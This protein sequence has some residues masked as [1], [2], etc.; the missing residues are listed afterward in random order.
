ML[1][2]NLQYHLNENPRIFKP[3]FTLKGVIG[4]K[5]IFFLLLISIC[6]NSSSSAVVIDSSYLDLYSVEA[7]DVQKWEQILKGI[8]E[9]HGVNIDYE[10]LTVKDI[11]QVFELRAH[12]E[13][14]EN[15]TEES[16]DRLHNNINFWVDKIGL[17]E[18][19]E[20]IK[21]T[22]QSQLRMFSI[23]IEKLE[24]Y[25]NFLESV[26]LVDA[27]LSSKRSLWS[28]MMRL[29]QVEVLV[30]AKNKS[31]QASQWL[32]WSQLFSQMN[33]E[34]SEVQRVFPISHFEEPRNSDFFQS[35][36]LNLAPEMLS[37]LRQYQEVVSKDF[38]LEVL[39]AS[40]G[41]RM[42]GMEMSFVPIFDFLMS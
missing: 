15:P 22:M 29:K 2:N 12:I 33:I 28:L 20:F 41:V 32:E 1:K 27:D 9:E 18:L 34:K 17:D 37:F 30:T 14:S 36:L 3:K 4:K 6:F 39:S 16:V 13:G 19:N 8:F 42:A 5:I 23:N 35:I 25:L 24:A 11:S 31:Y 10:R 38:L 21:I 26:G 7:S 40:R